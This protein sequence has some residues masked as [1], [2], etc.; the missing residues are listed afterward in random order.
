MTRAPS[1]PN[2]L[3]QLGERKANLERTLE[4]DEL[5]AWLNRAQKTKGS[6]DHDI[7]AGAQLL[8]TDELRARVA[9]AD[10]VARRK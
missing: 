5:L 8:A 10:Q 9:E 3:I 2:I 6:R 4:R 7:L 1:P